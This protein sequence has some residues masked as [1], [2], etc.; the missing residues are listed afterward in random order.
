MRRR[1]FINVEKKWL[2]RWPGWRRAQDDAMKWRKDF[3]QQEIPAPRHVCCAL[4]AQ[5]LAQYLVWYEVD[6]KAAWV[7]KKFRGD[8]KKI[9][10]T[11]KNH[12][13]RNKTN[14][15]GNFMQ[16]LLSSWQQ[17]PTKIVMVGLDAAGKTT[18]LYKL[19]LGEVSQKFFR[20]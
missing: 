6:S 11:N 8:T 16:R 18:V 19:K 2:A 12:T 15:M 5:A 17:Q 9:F 14:T 7:R 10:H 13:T 3:F 20:K 1:G 4:P